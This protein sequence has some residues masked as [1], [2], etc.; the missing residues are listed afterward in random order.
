MKW[1]VKLKE[2][3]KVA[4]TY[5]LSL[6]LFTLF[7]IV[8]TAYT[9][10]SGGNSSS[11]PS[12]EQ[13]IAGGNTTDPAAIST[14]SACATGQIAIG[15]AADHTVLCASVQ[16]LTSTQCPAHFSLVAAT[17]T[18]I[19]CLDNSSYAQTGQM[20]PIGSSLSSLT[21]QGN[22]VCSGF[23]FGTG[24][25]GLACP[26]GSYLS[27]ISANTALCSPLPS[28]SPTL[29][30]AGHY[31]T[32]FDGGTPTCSD[33]WWTNLPAV[34]CPAGKIL[35]GLN[36][37]QAAVC[38]DIK[39]SPLPGN[40]LCTGSD[41][42]KSF[43]AGVL[44]CQAP[45]ASSLQWMCPESTYPSSIQ[46]SKVVCVAYSNQ[47][48][49]CTNTQYVVGFKNGNPIC[50]NSNSF[51]ISSCPSNSYPIGYSSGALVCQ[52]FAQAK[53]G[54]ACISGKEQLCLVPNGIGHQVCQADGLSF[55]SCEV[56]A[57]LTGY[58]LVSGS[59][60]A[61]QCTPGSILSCRLPNAS[62]SSVCSTQG[63]PGP[64]AIS[65]CDSGYNLNAGACVPNSCQPGS[66]MACR[67]G[68]G[69]GTQ[70]CLASG[71]DYGTCQIKMC[72][73]GYSLS[74][75]TCVDVAIPK[76]T[77]VTA[78][79]NPTLGSNATVKF[80]AVDAQSGLSNVTCRLDTED[81]VDC[82]D[83]FV[84]SHLTSGP[85]VLFIT[86]V[87]KTGNVATQAVSWTSDVCSNETVPT[88]PIEQGTG[89]LACADDGTKGNICTV[90]TCNE[91]YQM[92]NNACVSLAC[93]P[94]FNPVGNAC[95]DNTA[96]VLTVTKAP[97]SVVTKESV[98]EFSAADLGSGVQRFECYLDGLAPAACLSPVSFSGLAV[99]N[100]NFR[101]F[102]Y[103]QQGNKASYE[104]NWKFVNCVPSTTSVCAVAN[105]IAA[106]T[107]AADGSGYGGCDISSCDAG[108][109]KTGQAC[110]YVPKSCNLP[111][112]AS[113]VDG[114]SISAYQNATVKAGKSCE[115]ETRTCHDGVLSGNYGN[116]GCRVL[117]PNIADL[118][119]VPAYR[120]RGVVDH[121]VS[122]SKTEG[123]QY[124]YHYIYEGFLFYFFKPAAG[125]DLVP[126][127]R[128]VGNPNSSY[129]HFLTRDPG[130]EGL[131]YRDE[132]V[133]GSLLRYQLPGSRPVYR[134]YKYAPA[135]FLETMDYME[136]VRYGYTLSVVIGYSL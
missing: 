111:W 60:Q 44:T 50:T 100:H 92:K 30:S 3:F 29:C 48:L 85:H 136:G 40:V 1:T 66:S 6:A 90:K 83:S 13:I 73:T 33:F 78:P 46:N 134:F 58:D 68:P 24:N 72:D 125:F 80:S 74:G 65:S 8:A 113:L 57:C 47:A 51:P 101:L 75:T 99:G 7:A 103:D 42:L 20:C 114:Q 5:R 26:V 135:P 91:G 22:L 81:E 104:Y 88:C 84:A 122:T 67:M 34:S 64:C 27:G 21:T 108:Y 112:G 12:A 109:V 127:H 31:M 56:A 37:T 63:Q 95:V 110:V 25:V 97:D 118:V 76:I 2:F 35:V 23:T 69:T 96:P 16:T 9:N 55:S 59:C 105:G 116:A 62:G 70:A 38:Q 41:I 87:D 126:I 71:A 132:G 93:G 128:C 54:P 124:P 15:I 82:V 4:Q 130:C 129:N 52:T 79:A 49:S 28:P 102:A 14:T 19:S 18:T 115:S 45:P 107:C 43:E 131:P 36:A 98:F 119:R 53:S 77:I 11:S 121:M 106:K 123:S 133:I 17:D 86:A 117:P 89:I 39:L 10:C 32:G 61:S 94:G 120:L